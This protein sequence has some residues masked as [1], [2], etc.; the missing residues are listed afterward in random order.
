MEA[1]DIMSRIDT[2]ILRL[3]LRMIAYLAV[4]PATRF[5]KISLGHGPVEEI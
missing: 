1:E 4:V 3:A 2:R 5:F